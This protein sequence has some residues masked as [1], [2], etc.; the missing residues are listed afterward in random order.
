M[1]VFTFHSSTD[2]SISSVLQCYALFMNNTTD[3]MSFFP[4]TCL[5]FLLSSESI[6]EAKDIPVG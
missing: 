4:Q 5:P 6:I 2:R 3:G 1:H